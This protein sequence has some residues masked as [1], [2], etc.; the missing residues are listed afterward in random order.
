MGRHT[1]DSSSDRDPREH[2]DR[3]VS[4]ERRAAL[5]RTRTVGSS[6]LTA[7][8]SLATA[9][10]QTVPEVTGPVTIAPKSVAANRVSDASV[11]HAVPRTPADPRIVKQRR[12]RAVAAPAHDAPMRGVNSFMR[13]RATIP[14]LSFF[15]VFGFV[16]GS[17]FNPMQPDVAQAAVQSAVLAKAPAAAPQQFTPH[18]TYAAFDA[19]RDGYDVTVPKP[20]VTKAPTADATADATATDD[21]TT[22]AAASTQ[23]SATNTLA[24]TAATP[25]P[26]SAQAIAQQMV[27]ARGW[28]TDQYNCLVSLWNKE[29][30]WRVNAYNPSGAYGIPQALPGSKM[31]SAGADWQ[32]NPATQITWGLNYISGVYGT[33]CG[34][35][36]HSVA[37][38]WY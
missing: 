33:P 12:A 11:A 27:S 34:A 6:V 5:N 9:A 8:T 16:G 1:A 36:A 15:A 25:D 28:G 32:T 24:A 17:L 13:K 2:L 7:D 4:G 21:T 31:A 23:V 14:A 26:G 22:D 18:G 10:P 37:N 20:K 38:N 3:T 29:S 30:G 35:W 19:G